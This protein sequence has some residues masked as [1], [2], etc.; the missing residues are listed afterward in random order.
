MISLGHIFKPAS[1]SFQASR[2]TI[3]ERRPSCSRR[4]EWWWRRRRRTG[5]WGRRWSSSTPPSPS[6]ASPPSSSPNPPTSRKAHVSWTGGWNN[7][8]NFDHLRSLWPGLRRPSSAWA[9]S[10]L[11]NRCRWSSLVQY[12]IFNIQY[13]ISNIQYSN[14]K[15]ILACSIFTALGCAGLPFIRLSFMILVNWGLVV[16][17]WCWCGCRDP[18]DAND[19]DDDSRTL[20][21]RTTRSSCGSPKRATSAPT[22]PGSGTTSP[23]K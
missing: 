8:A 23:R 13:S 1:D 7:P 4:P 9:A 10:P 15:V 12:S 17:L 11:R 6:P 22:M 5:W 20:G 3:K 18:S 16:P 19:D 21:L 2:S 14:F